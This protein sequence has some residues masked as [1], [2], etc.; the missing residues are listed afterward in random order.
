VEGKAKN[1]LVTGLPGSGKT[2]LIRK[3]VEPL[4][5]L[6]PVG[7]Y[8]EEIR[9]GAIRQGFRLVD[10]EGEALTLSHISIH[11]RYRVGKYGVDISGFE[12]Y[13]KSRAFLAAPGRTIIIDEIGKMECLSKGFVRMM[14]EILESDKILLATI[15]LKGF[16]FID[17]IKHRR[18]VQL[19]ELT[20][21]NRGILG[22]EIL[23]RMARLSAALDIPNR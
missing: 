9:E 13:L 23:E 2:T 21:Q 20:V 18:D 17:E 15:A 6:R 7:F 11:S 3:L 5:P 4:R 22:A 12:T 10:L 1:I 14:S 8:T 16:G 19:I